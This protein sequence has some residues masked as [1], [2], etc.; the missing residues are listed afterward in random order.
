M[1]NSKFS[2]VY[3]MYH[4]FLMIIVVQYLALLHSFKTNDEFPLT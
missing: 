4:I 1:Q 2:S 3:P